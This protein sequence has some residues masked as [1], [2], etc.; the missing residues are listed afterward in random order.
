MEIINYCHGCQ[1]PTPFNES[2]NKESKESFNKYWKDSDESFAGITKIV[3][4]VCLATGLGL[5]ALSITAISLKAFIAVSAIFIA[6][7]IIAGAILTIA[8]AASS[9]ISWRMHQKKADLA[10]SIQL[11]QIH[12]IEKYEPIPKDKPIA[13]LIEAKEDENG[14]L[15]MSFPK[16]LEPNYRIV[17]CRASNIN[18]ILA[19][20]D[21]IQIEK[22]GVLWIQAHGLPNAFVL[23]STPE[24]KFGLATNLLDTTAAQPF[25]DVLNKLPKKASVVLQSCSTGAYQVEKG[26]PGL[27]RKL[28]QK[29]TDRK[30]FAPIR[31]VWR[32]TVKKSNNVLQ[33]IMQDRLLRN[34][35]T[36]YVNGVKHLEPMANFN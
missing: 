5:L 36:C 2:L 33:L 14:A 24:T 34:L 31:E 32:F 8:G 11:K 15:R 17:S 22:I 16:S 19:S 10:E 23:D 30:I 26:G 13:L 29:L 12:S 6:V 27:A 3:G 4:I 28:S 35:K 9:F 25:V 7:G 1:K 20:I 21:K 18:D